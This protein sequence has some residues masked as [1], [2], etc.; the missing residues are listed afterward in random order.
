M[1][2]DRQIDQ[3]CPHLVVEE[4]LFVGT[5]RRTI[6]PMKSVASA[7]SVVLRFNGEIQVPSFGVHLPARATGSKDGPYTILAGVND[8]LTIR[9]DNGELQ[10]VIVPPATTLSAARLVAIL[11]TNLLG[12]S[13][14]PTGNRVSFRTLSEGSGASLFFDPTST[15][16]SLLGFPTP[17]EFRGQT[18]IPG[19]TLVRD[20]AAISERPA[21]FIVFDEMLRSFSDF[22][23][24]SYTTARP[25][26]RRC[27]GIGIENDWRYGGTGETVQ[28]RDEALLRQEIQKLFLTARGSNTFHPF[29][30]TTIIEAIGKKLTQGA[31]F[32]N[33][34]VTDVG[35]TFKS[36]QDIKRKQ[37][38]LVGQ[39]ISDEEFPY[40]LLGVNLLP[41]DKDPTVIFLKIT[42]Q[43][44]SQ[45]AIVL[46]RG[47]K[48]PSA[49]DIASFQQ[50]VIRQSLRNP[51][52]SGE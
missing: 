50:G 36:W 4:A 7:A 6:R 8:R 49:F 51:V 19:W 10:T 14:S 17:R 32:Q 44:R 13:F 48:L 5:D 25:D 52:F 27:G 34:L 47:L 21:R 46:E 31:L 30:G 26:C 37:E 2:Y 33:L 39:I 23:E 11:N 40:R 20:P 15:L 35:Q 12:V 18:T 3:V 9:V 29:Y 16:V 24:V 28:V 1:S 45:K 42:I 43:N 38:E 41:S 22:V